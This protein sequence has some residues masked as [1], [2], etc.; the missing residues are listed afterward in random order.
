VGDLSRLFRPRSIVVFG[1]WWAENVIEQCLKSGFDGDIWP[2]HPKREAIHGIP[3]HR[4]LAD[5]PG[6]PDAAFLG[7]NRHAVVEVAAEL[8]AMGCGGA[9]CFAS[10]FAETGDH[11]LQDKLVAAAGD[12]P[13]LGPNCYGVL[14]YLDGAMLWPDQHGGRAV[15][16]GVAIISQSSNIAIN[17]SMQARGLPIAYIACVGNQA[18]TGL[19]DMA[20]SLLADPRVTAAGLYVEGFT[21]SADFAAMADE[22]VAAG[23]HIVAIKSGRTAAARDAAS[24]HTAA[25]AGDGAASSAFLE[26]CGVIEV[27]SP[28]DMMEVLKILHLHGRLDGQRVTAMCCS[29]GEAGLTADLADGLRLEWPAIPEANRAQLSETLGPLVALANPLDYHT[30][31]WG[32]EAKMADT[33]AAMMGD[34]VDMSVLVIDFPRDDRC[35]DEAWHPA[36]AAMKAAGQRTGTKTAMLGSLAEG[37]SESWAD[38]LLADG[39]VPLCGFE[40]GFRAIARTTAPR[41]QS[42]WRPLAACPEPATRRLVDEAAAK[43]ILAKAA[44][45]VPRG[46]TASMPDDLAAAASCLEGK[47]VLKGLGHAHKSEVGLVRLDLN[48]AEL[49]GAAEKMAET[50][51]IGREGFLVEEMAPP[52]V[53]ELLVG[54]RRDPVYGISLSIG[55]GGVT[56]E[57]LGD[58]AT[59]ILPAT[60]VEIHAA[61]GRLQLAPLLNGFRGRPL[62]DIEAAVTAISAM[63]ELITI[64]PTIDEIEVNPLILGETGT[65][66]LAVD[67]VLWKTDH[68]G[69]S[70]KE[71]SS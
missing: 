48:Q 45:A 21:D 37:V 42:G 58:V 19:A 34:W 50:G 52:P 55:M 32:D 47:L 5:L 57:L 7:I 10:G 27:D 40:H 70:G 61:I 28:E 1:G 53:A 20:R 3:C 24:S 36:V 46:V 11:N 69:S 15:D 14:N 26:R 4:S 25:L 60:P 35:S 31:I 9:V 6:V 66:V 44:V 68:P 64:D 16:T 63:A 62:A 43:S 67:A 12:M 33:F 59:L 29:G 13:L 71:T 30:F 22:A 39:I 38:S 49:A 17:I 23:K 18:Q 8:S 2:V 65:G 41:P 51:M 56:A 54:L